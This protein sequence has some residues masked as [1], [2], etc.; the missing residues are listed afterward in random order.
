M[1]KLM[2]SDGKEIEVPDGEPIKQYAKMLN[3]A[4]GCENGLCATCL[5]E[6]IEG[7][8]NLSEQSDREKEMELTKDFRLA[9]QCKLK[10]G[11]VKFKY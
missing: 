5:L 2:R 4:F 10:S 1:G 11:I 6:I 7:A 9:C 8:E 3:V